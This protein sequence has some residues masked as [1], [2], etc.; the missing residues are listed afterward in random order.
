MNLVVKKYEDKYKNQVMQLIC[1]EYSYELSSY[2]SFFNQ[3]YESEFQ[4][5]ALKTIVIDEDKN[6]LVVGFF[7]LFNWPYKLNNQKIMAWKGVNAIVMPSY[8]GNGIF[9]KILDFVDIQLQ[10]QNNV[11]FLIATPLPAAFYGFKKNGWKHLLDLQWFIKLNNPFAFLFPITKK[12]NTIFNEKKSSDLTAIDNFIHQDDSSKFNSWRASYYKTKKYYLSYTEGKNIVQFGVKINIRKKII[13]ELI[14]GEVA[15][16]YFEEEFMEKGFN[17]LNK[18]INKLPF[19]TFSSIAINPYHHNINN[20]IQK[21]AYKKINKI[22]HIVVKDLTGK[23]S[24]LEKE[25]WIL[26]RADL[27]SW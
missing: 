26:Y 27:D 6:K 21:V 9:K 16:N 14:V 23:T 18:K 3:F 1:N 19:I 25:K 2:I 20:I 11:D 4:E 15:T 7:A 5:N 13:R 12:I 10:H 24:S 8:R 22:I 17:Y